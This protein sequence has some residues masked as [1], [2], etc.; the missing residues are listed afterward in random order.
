M[1]DYYKSNSIVKAFQFDPNNCPYFYWPTP[2]DKGVYDV[3]IED[4]PTIMRVNDWFV[5]EQIGTQTINYI[6]SPNN[7]NLIMESYNMEEHM[8]DSQI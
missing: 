8:V 4:K 2:I 7:F 3:V 6:L 1:S 5:S